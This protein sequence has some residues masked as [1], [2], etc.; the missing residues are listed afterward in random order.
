M[1]P[2]NHTNG[3][4]LQKIDLADDL[5]QVRLAGLLVA[6]LAQAK[7]VQHQV[8]GLLQCDLG[9]FFHPLILAQLEEILCFERY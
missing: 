8:A 3:I 5:Q 2:G 6:V 9:Q 4:H 7:R 1:R